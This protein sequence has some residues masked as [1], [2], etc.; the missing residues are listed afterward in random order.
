VI[1]PFPPGPL[2]T[3]LSAFAKFEAPQ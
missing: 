2:E 1:G 3:V